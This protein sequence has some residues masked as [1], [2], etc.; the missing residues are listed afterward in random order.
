MRTPWRAAPRRRAS[1]VSLDLLDDENREQLR[2]VLGVRVF[3]PL[4]HT[5]VRRAAGLY[6]RARPPIE[7]EELDRAVSSPSSVTS[8]K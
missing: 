3:E 1:P 8:W 6:D 2:I 5:Q 7:P 4:G